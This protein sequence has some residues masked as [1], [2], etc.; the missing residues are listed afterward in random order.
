MHDFAGDAGR[1]VDLEN[2]QSRFEELE[3]PELRLTDIPI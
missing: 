1:E 2:F 3:V